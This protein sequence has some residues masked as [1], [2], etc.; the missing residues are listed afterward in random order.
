VNI[1]QLETQFAEL[2]GLTLLVL[3]GIRLVLHEWKQIVAAWRKL[4]KPARKVIPSP[5]P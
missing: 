3:G 2:L 4:R 5:T 1:P